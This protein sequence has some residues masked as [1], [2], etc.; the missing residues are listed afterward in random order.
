MPL[1]RF[2]QW[3]LGLWLMA[4][5]LS[6]GLPVRAQGQSALVLSLDGPLTAPM[7]SYLERGLQRAQRENA[8]VV[9]LQ[10]NTPGGEV[11]LME[12]LVG[13]IRN[14]AT[15]VIVYVSPR[16]AMAGSAGTLITL[17]GHVAAMAPETAIGAASPIGGQGEELDSTSARKLKEMMR[18][19]VRA[20]AARRPPEAIAL[21][22]AAIE[23]AKAVSAQEALDVGLIDFIAQDIPDLLRQ[24]NEFVVEVNGQPRALAT[25]G[26]VVEEEN[27]NLLETILSLLTNPNVVF[28][29]MSLGGLLLWVE[30]S[31]PGGWVAGFLGVICMALAF[32]GLGVLPVNWF[33]IIFIILAFVLFVMD[34]QAPTHG[35]LTAAAV[36]SLIVG[37]LVLFNSPGSVPYFR[38]SVPFVI[39]LSLLI[40]GASFGLLLIALR[41]QNRPALM[42]AQT[43]VGQAGDVRTANSVYVGGELWTAE[44][45]DGQPLDVGQTVIVAEVRGLKVRVR[46]K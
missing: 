22:E 1:T 46:R 38:V 19:Q 29:L 42:G 5:L 13:V 27:W 30:I 11:S 23:S 45:E 12:K 28:S 39:I 41:A 7:L 31:Q 15:P 6:A 16:G 40:G 43:L 10:L 25:T 18:A 17:A 33:G 34:V 2:R 24:V 44:A 20:L 14:S 26:L 3:L 4:V 37:A 21:A 36:G 9:I 35:A 8:E 32:Y